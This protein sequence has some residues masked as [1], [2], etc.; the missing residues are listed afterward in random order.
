MTHIA[1]VRKLL[2]TMR[3]IAMYL[4]DEEISQIGLILM[5]AIKRMESEG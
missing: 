4:T 1:K 2:E 3:M 5:K